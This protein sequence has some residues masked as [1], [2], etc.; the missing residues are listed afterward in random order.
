MQNE[1]DLNK[2]ILPRQDVQ[3]DCST[4]QIY[5]LP[6]QCIQERENPLDLLNPR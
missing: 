5:Q 2:Q 6:D 4:Q 1:E 3:L